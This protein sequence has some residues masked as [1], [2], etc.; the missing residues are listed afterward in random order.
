MFCNL[1]GFGWTPTPGVTIDEI[2]RSYK[3]DGQKEFPHASYHRVMAVEEFK[4]YYGGVFVTIK[5]HKKF[6]ELVRD[7]AGRFKISISQAAGENRLMDFNFFVVHK[8]MGRGLYLHYHNSTTFNVFSTFIAKRHKALARTKKRS[9]KKSGIAE[10]NLE[11]L[12]DGAF[13]AERIIRPEDFPELLRELD[14]IKE[15]KFD[16]LSLLVEEDAFRSLTGDAKRVSHVV[17]FKPKIQN[18]NGLV[19]KISEFV[20]KKKI[21][22]GRV[23]GKDKQGNRQ[24]VSLGENISIFD[25]Y[26]FDEIAETAAGDLDNIKDSKLLKL[27]LDTAKKNK[28]TL[29]KKAK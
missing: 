29:L 21:E 17:M 26:E 15:F 22:K 3:K 16:L 20:K 4:D 24:I 28:N 14:E 19:A 27:I 12:Y 13:L 8:K 5:D 25:K 18:K 10:A 11:K 6:C 2:L 7:K 1:Q 9:D 23:T